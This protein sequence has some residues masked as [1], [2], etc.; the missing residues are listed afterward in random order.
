M[1][2]NRF[3]VTPTLK[4]DVREI[5]VRPRQA[6]HHAQPD[7][8]TPHLKHDRDCRSCGFRGERDLG[9]AGR[10]DDGDLTI[11]QVRRERRQSVISTVCPLEFDRD[12]PALDV[13]GFG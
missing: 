1:K 6:T 8:V 10:D 3:G 13:A 9:A 11:D 7:R 4:F 5:A 12:V 2:S